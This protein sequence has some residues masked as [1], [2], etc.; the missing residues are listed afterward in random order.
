MIS[1][2]L[3]VTGNLDLIDSSFFVCAGHGIYLGGESPL[4]GLLVTNH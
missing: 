4:W 1:I 2:L 3:V